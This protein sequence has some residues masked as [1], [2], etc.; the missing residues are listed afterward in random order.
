MK[1]GDWIISISVLIIALTIWG[2]LKLTASFQQGDNLMLIVKSEGVVVQTLEVDATTSASYQVTNQ[3]GYNL[4]WVRDGIVSIHEA[5][6]KNQ[7]C[8]NYGGISKSGQSLVCL[9]HR[10]IVE[11]KGAKALE[12]DAV[13]Q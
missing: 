3:Y 8:V 11:L 4:I 13:S 12:V 2:G 1:K 5:D 6:C 10:V 7:L 9:P